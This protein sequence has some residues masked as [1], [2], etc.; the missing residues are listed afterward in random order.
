MSE[1]VKK[2]AADASKMLVKGALQ[3]FANVSVPTPTGVSTPVKPGTKP[4]VDTS[5][6]VSA[7]P[8]L[9]DGVNPDE[10]P[11]EELLSL[12]MKINK[13][14]QLMEAKGQE[15]VKKKGTL[16]SERRHLLDALKLFGVITPLLNSNSADDVDLDTEAIVDEVKRAEEER[17][18]DI[19]T[20]LQKIAK[21]EEVKISLS[22]QLQLQSI[23]SQESKPPSDVVNDGLLLEKEAE[24]VPTDEVSRVLLSPET[25]SF[26]EIRMMTAKDKLRVSKILSLH[27]QLTDCCS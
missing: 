11:R 18:A 20:L 23:S 27:V 9:H 3:L 24:V 1:S 12:C 17:R 15:L 4:P 22:S 21:L 7:S 8:M 14:M 26:G 6:G 5:I 2:N 13:R 10:I 16:L 25:S 19:S